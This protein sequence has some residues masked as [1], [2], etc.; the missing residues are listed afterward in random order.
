MKVVLARHLECSVS[1]GICYGRTDVSLSTNAIHHIP[2]VAAEISL[3]RI[4]RV[5][6]SPASRCRVLGEAV[7]I[8]SR[9]PLHVD[10]CLS[11]L[12]FGAWEGLPWNDLL[13]ADLDRWADD[14]LTFSPP[15]GENGQALLDRVRQVHQAIRATGDDCAVIS[16]G[17]PLKVLSALLRGVE[18]DLLAPQPAIG[19]ITIIVC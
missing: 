2:G 10:P 8:T 3:H 12:D 19:S 5:W 16:H 15:E 1:P 14:P 9:V 4:S 13:R 11:E 17:G 7:A 6:T 18:P